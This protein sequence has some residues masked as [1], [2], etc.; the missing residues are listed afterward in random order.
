MNVNKSLFRFSELAKD[1]FIMASNLRRL[2]TFTTA[3][4]IRNIYIHTMPN[5]S[6]IDQRFCGSMRWVS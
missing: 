2:T 3:A 4:P 5:E 6:T 1:Q